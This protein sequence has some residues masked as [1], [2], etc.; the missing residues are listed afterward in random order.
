M[1]FLYRLWGVESELAKLDAP[2]DR[3]ATWNAAV[4][5]AGPW[6][7]TRLVTTLLLAAPL[8]TILLRL[9]PRFA[10]FARPVAPAPAWLLEIGF[11]AAVWVSWYFLIMAVCGRRMRRAVR[12]LLR[13]RGVHVCL[14]CGYDLRGGTG[15]R[16]P[17]CGT[18]D[19]PAGGATA[20]HRPDGAR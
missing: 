20:P 14:A 2:T 11:A 1:Q 7:Q 4:R 18:L 17:E 13:A 12:E 10:Q 8:L 15:V 9:P 16:C 5:R 6:A 3:E 19:R